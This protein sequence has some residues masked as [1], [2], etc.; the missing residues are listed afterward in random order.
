MYWRH[1]LRWCPN[2]VGSMCSKS[3]PGR[4]EGWTRSALCPCHLCVPSWFCSCGLP[5]SQ[6]RVTPPRFEISVIPRMSNSSG[7]FFN[8]NR[9]ILVATGDHVVKRRF[10]VSA[11]T[12]PERPIIKVLYTVY[13]YFSSIADDPSDPASESPTSDSDT[14]ALPLSPPCSPEFCPR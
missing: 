11:R 7:Y 8:E 14:A 9:Q 12:E 10:G 2:L 13:G 4:R 6:D 3:R 5:K 1:P